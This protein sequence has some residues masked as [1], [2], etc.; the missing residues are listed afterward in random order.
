MDAGDKFL[1]QT[2]AADGTLKTFRTLLAGGLVGNTMSLEGFFEGATWPSFYTGVTPARHGFHRMT[3]LKPGTYEFYRCY[4]GDFIRHEP[5][6]NYL[7]RAGRRVAI[8][9]IPLS[10][11]SEKI[12]G[13]QMVEWGS[14]DPN[15]GFCTW[16]QELKRDVLGRFGQHPLRETCDSFRRTP[17]AFCV[18]RDLLLQGVQKKTEL[19]NYYLN[20]DRWDFFAQVFTESHCVGHQ[21]WHLHDP[22]HPGYDPEV[23]AI[24]GNP[25]RDVYI[26]IDAAI[27]EILT[28]IDDST[29]VVFLASH[30]MA[31]SFGAQFLLPAILVRLEVA[32]ACS[33]KAL[34]GQPPDYIDRLDAVLTWGWQ[35]MSSRIK[36]KLTPV[37]DRLRGWID[38][39]HP[40]LP[41]SCS[42]MDIKRSKC[43]PLDNGLS[44][45]GIR[46]NLAGRE[47]DGII[48]PGAEMDAFC[49][50]LAHNLLRIVDGDT[51]IPMIKSVRRTV[52]LYRGECLDHLPDL[53]V[54]WSDEK[55]LGTIGT[56]NP[57]G[58]KVRLASEKI[59]II[60]GVNAYCRTGDHRAE[61]LFIA[62]GSGIKAGRLKRTVSLMD[63]APTFTNL[64]GVGLPHADGEP[65]TEILEACRTLKHGY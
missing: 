41:S 47:P 10:G 56:R 14:H 38:G 24:T 30:R 3:Q 32:E 2:W 50:E 13:L 45:G 4:T 29:L 35:S 6:W 54:E 43:F 20:T 65:I 15:C 44:V 19:T 21:C 1:I 48:K 23:V 62:F 5:F 31:H 60:E 25:V 7:S 17:Q 49:E 58:S 46:V 9:D 8:L 26:A 40:H 18:F 37:R 34:S 64:L 51:G 12:N 11:I 42:G 57:G 36:E 22:G 33:A 55:P 61:G 63:F 16:P 28:Q 39:R 59:G 52:D 53:L 27:G